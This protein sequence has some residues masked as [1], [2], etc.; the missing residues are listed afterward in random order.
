MG[1]RLVI[2]D[3]EALKRVLISNVFNY[4]KPETIRVPLR[5]MIGDG[6]VTVEGADHTRQRKVVSGAFRYDCV[7]QLSP[8]FASKTN[9][10]TQIWI[11]DAKRADG[12]QLVVDIGRAMHALT[13]DVIGLAAFGHDFRA[14]RNEGDKL[15]AAYEEI[16]SGRSITL[17]NVVCR[18]WPFSLLP[19]PKRMRDQRANA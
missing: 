8:I 11:D 13:I 19:W 4:P 7:A 2:G 14:V 10:L 12:N 3:A 18:I 6:L 15:L 16:L 9:E 5:F 1:D 17:A